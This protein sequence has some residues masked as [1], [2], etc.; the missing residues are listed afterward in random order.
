MEL[1]RWFS[2]S[3]TDMLESDNACL[4]ALMLIIR[5]WT[6]QLVPG[7]GYVLETRSRRS[8]S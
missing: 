1:G 6:D 4:K 3:S 5:Q 7:G 2:A 8:K